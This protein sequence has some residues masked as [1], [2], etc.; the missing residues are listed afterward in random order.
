MMWVWSL[1][2]SSS[3]MNWELIDM[4][5]TPLIM[6]EPYLIGYNNNNKQSLIPLGGVG[7]MDKTTP[8]FSIMN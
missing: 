6:D 1:C 3:M 2:I 8:L 4:V 5:G 7:Y